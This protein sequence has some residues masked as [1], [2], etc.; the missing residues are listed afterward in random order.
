[1][2]PPPRSPRRLLAVALAATWPVLVAGCGDEDRDLGSAGT[3][4]ELVEVAA[5]VTLDVLAE[6]EGLTLAELPGDAEDPFAALRAPYEGFDERASEL[7][8][9]EAEL[10]RLACDTYASVAAEA[11]GEVAEAFLAAYFAACD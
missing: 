2:R 4:E 7:G 3:C 11:S 9:G 5:D 1:V 8:C 10:V 6:V